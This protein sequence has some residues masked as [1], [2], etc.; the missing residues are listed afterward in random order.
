MIL[1]GVETATE[2]L[3][4][5]PFLHSPVPPRLPKVVDVWPVG[6]ELS[7]SEDSLLQAEKALAHRPYVRGVV[8]EGRYRVWQRRRRRRR[9]KGCMKPATR[10]SKVCLL[11]SMQEGHYSAIINMYVIYLACSQNRNSRLFEARSR[12]ARVSSQAKI[13]RYKATSSLSC[14]ES[15]E[16]PRPYIPPSSSVPLAD[17]H[18][19]SQVLKSGLAPA[20][21]RPRRQRQA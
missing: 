10:V 15:W 1:L 18:D 11:F 13:Q 3:R 20:P 16:H 5:T 8:V 6:L 17:T 12:N 21:K 7:G 14:A 2:V 9:R 19:G 4:L